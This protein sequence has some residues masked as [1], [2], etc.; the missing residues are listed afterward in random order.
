MRITLTGATGFIGSRLIQHW[1][2]EN[3]ELH[4]LGRSGRKLPPAVRFWQWAEPE[5]TDPP[6]ES[7]DG[8]QAVI[9]L[10]GEPVA[11]RWTDEAKQ[12]IRSSR[13]EVTS[14]LVSAISRL[15]SKPSVLVSAS[16]VGYYG[17]RG[18]EVLTEDSLP[19]R[20]FLPDICVEWEQRAQQATVAGVR[21]VCLRTG[22]VLGTEGGA[23]PQMLPPFRLGFGGPMG[24]GEQWMPWI[25]LD[26]IVGLIDFASKTESLH[27]PL[28][29]CSPNPVTNREFS[30]QLGRALHRPAVVPVPGFAIKLLFGE[31]AQVVLASDRAVPKAALAGGYCFHF[32][33]L[34][35]A[36]N[37]LLH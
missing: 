28:N 35:A 20:G 13:V 37:Q 11:Q 36:L 9:H 8:S 33:E 25:H 14:R 24:N 32:P 27:G 17:S 19:G 6:A 16:A 23:L 12:R 15:Q 26:D 7:L 4:V 29:G 3:H 30:S 31:M 22:I 2:R 10:A 34:C 18:D 1:L 5:R 21:V